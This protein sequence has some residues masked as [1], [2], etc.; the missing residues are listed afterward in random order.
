MN[1]PQSR[2]TRSLAD[3]VTGE[4]YENAAKAILE[5]VFGTDVVL[6]HGEPVLNNPDHRQHGQRYGHA[7]LEIRGIALDV[8]KVPV[9]AMSVDEY[10]NKGQIDTDKVRRYSHQEA[11]QAMR[12]HR[13]YGPWNNLATSQVDRQTRPQPPRRGV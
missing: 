1:T 11:R 5:G 4:C 8:T 9:V 6:C 13:T 12:T 10:Y 2:E 3:D 7:W